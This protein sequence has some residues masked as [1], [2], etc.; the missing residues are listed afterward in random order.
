MAMLPASLLSGITQRLSAISDTPVLDASV[1]LAYIVDKPRTWVLAHP[2]LKLTTQ[3][4]R[5][6]DESLARLE[7]GESFPYVLGHWEFFGMDF[8]VTPDVLIPRPETEFHP[9]P[10]RRG[11]RRRRSNLRHR[12]ERSR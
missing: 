9:I 1:L 3:Q 5:Q 11:S 4:K 7:R 12:P 6:L 10:R 2:E 8:E